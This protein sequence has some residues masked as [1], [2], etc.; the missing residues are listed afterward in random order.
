VNRL[1]ANGAQV[2]SHA[3]VNVEVDLILMNYA[4]LILSANTIVFD[5]IVSIDAT[6]T[7]T[8]AGYVATFNSIVTMA[9]PSVVFA[10]GVNGVGAI[11][12]FTNLGIL[13]ITQFA[14]VSSPLI[15]TEIICTGNFISSSSTIYNNVVYFNALA[16]VTF[17]GGFPVFNQDTYFNYKT[18]LHNSGA[19]ITF[20][21]ATYMLGTCHQNG[22]MVISANFISYGTFHQNSGTISGVGGIY[23]YSAGNFYVGSGSGDLSLNVYVSNANMYT[24]G[25]MNFIGAVSLSSGGNFTVTSGFPSFTNVVSLSSSSFF[26][27]YSDVSVNFTGLVSIQGSMVIKKG[28][29]TLPG[30]SPIQVNLGGVLNLGTT[31]VISNG[32]TVSGGLL[33]LTQAATFQSTVSFSSSG[34]LVQ[35]GNVIVF[36]GPVTVSSPITFQTYLGLERSQ[37]QPL[38]FS[39]HR[40]Q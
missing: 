32:V 23:V 30:T 25:T 38:E 12:F 5:G 10:T 37:Y 6:S 27:I 18:V 1:I 11:D 40:L 8:Q 29:S 19:N 34:K 24:L 4:S 17:G 16:I 22:I 20:S 2:G 15:S 14:N 39:P 31:G 7:F 36:N 21:G 28:T 13:M 9:C 26:V 3:N 33:T 35:N